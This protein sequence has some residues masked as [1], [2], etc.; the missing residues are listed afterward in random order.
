MSETMRLHARR[1]VPMSLGELLP[2]PMP[3]QDNAAP[4]LSRAFALMEEGKTSLSGRY[5]LVSELVRYH[6]DAETGA[7]NGHSLLLLS[8]AS[9]Q[10]LLRA[11]NGKSLAAVFSLLEDAAEKPGCRFDADPDRAAVGGVPHL[12]DLRNSV[13]LLL[14]RAWLRARSGAADGALRDVRRCLLLTPHLRHD[15]LLVSQLVRASCDRLAVRRLNGIVN[16]VALDDLEEETLA[17]VIAAAGLA[18]D[19]R[20]EGLVRALDGERII[21]GAWFGK[22]LLAGWRELMGEED[23]EEL[24]WIL[25]LY[26]QYIGRPLLKRDL[27]CY[28]LTMVDYRELARRPFPDLVALP[29]DQTAP[30]CGVLTRLIS[31]SVRGCCRTVALRQTALELARVGLALCLHRKQ[32]DAYPASLAEL[33]SLSP[34]PSDP[35][36]AGFLYRRRDDGFVVYSVGPDLKDDGGAARTPK[37]AIADCVWSIGPHSNEMP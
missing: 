15:P 6:D 10:G 13:R 8:P 16:M 26:P 11:V 24:P 25:R 18:L 1:G 29:D 12:V 20:N 2:E 23:A 30:R 32:Q 5:T 22:Q 34:A 4:V 28:M 3:R 21:Y 27:R 7:G 33:A 31:P 17:G 37:G 9:V 19:E 36:G 35:F 14:L